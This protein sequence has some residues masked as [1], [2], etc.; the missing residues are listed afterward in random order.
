MSQAY[1]VVDAFTDQLFRG[2]PAGV[3]P[4][5]AWLLD[6]TMQKIA[7]ENNLAETAFFVA[8]SPGDYDLRWFTPTIEIDL[9]G[10]ATL[11][12]A[13]VLWNHLGEKSDSLLFHSLSGELK[14]VRKNGRLA[15][16][17][18][19]RPADKIVE[20]EGLV[21]AFGLS[22]AP[23]WIGQTED[24]FLIVFGSQQEVLDAAPDF[25]LLAAFPM[26]RF[27]L[28][29]PGENGIDFVSR[30][31]APQA[32]V[33]EDPVTGS[34]H[35]TLIPYWSERL[36]RKVLRAKQVSP[37]GGDLFCE[38]LGDRVLIAGNAATYLRGEIF[39]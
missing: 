27:I 25:N 26:G 13:H 15:L 28:S 11:A 22:S 2:N 7:T 3:C 37:R 4:L 29:A 1:Y 23:A 9:C 24:R 19:S 34:S 6:E 35:C 12:S 5:K 38:D 17:F 33:P 21:R 31:F 39:I 20:P 10:H 36:G 30:F 8:R 18:P 32:G 16:D 14:V